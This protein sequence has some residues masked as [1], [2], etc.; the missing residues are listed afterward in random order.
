M[1]TCCKLMRL[2]SRM[3]PAPC[4]VECLA[5]PAPRP[6]PSTGRK[7]R[8]APDA[9]RGTWFE[10]AA[11]YA[12]PALRCAGTRAANMA[13]HREPG[14]C[15]RRRQRGRRMSRASCMPP[16]C[17]APA[18]CAADTRPA[19]AELADLVRDSGSGGGDGGA[20]GDGPRPDGGGE[21]PDGGGSVWAIQSPGAS[22]RGAA[23]RSA[24]IDPERRHV[25]A[26]P[27]RP[28]LSQGTITVSRPR[29]VVVWSFGTLSRACPGLG[30]AAAQLLAAHPACAHARLGR[31]APAPAPRAA[32]ARPLATRLLC[33]SAARRAAPTRPAA[34]RTGVAGGGRGRA[35]A[36]GGALPRGG[37]AAAG[38]GGRRDLRRARAAPAAGARAA[39]CRWQGC[40]GAPHS[41]LCVQRAGDAPQV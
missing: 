31:A 19:I 32:P 15:S 6:R 11:P 34:A 7:T 18:Q 39:A 40:R 26:R 28:P 1:Q 2:P 29:S 38:A 24:S 20:L 9:C 4:P 27:L 30:S 16:P 22:P 13:S 5:R 25:C 17:R 14:V 37:A 36:G 12:A 41:R 8:C 35:A 10:P 33:A 23:R 3:T 21:E